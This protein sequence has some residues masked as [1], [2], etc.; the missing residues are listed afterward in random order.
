MEEINAVGI[1]NQATG[2]IKRGGFEFTCNPYVGCSFGCTYCYAAFLPQNRRPIEDWGKWLE[3]KVNAVELA[4]KKAKSL[5]GKTVYISSV[6]DPYLPVE[7]RLS[8]TRGILEALLPHQPRLLIQ[9]RGPI[10]VRDID[11]FKQFRSIRVNVSIPGDCEEMRQV[12]EPKAPPLDRRWLALEDL[13]AEGVPVGVCVTPMLPLVD[14]ASFVER[15]VKLNP[16]VVVTQHFHCSTGV[17]ANTGSTA[18]A[19]LQRR[20]WTEADYARC[21]AELRRKLTVYEGEEGFFPPPAIEARVKQKELP[22]TV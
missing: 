10:V 7:R 5:A 12:F 1:F 17:G 8:L 2:F 21:V 11:L 20:N 16:A 15:I 3:A 6:T 18:L 22:L 4:K 9:T 14:P 13:A 19:E